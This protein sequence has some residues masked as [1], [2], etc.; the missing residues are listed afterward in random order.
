MG[1]PTPVL[2]LAYPPANGVKAGPCRPSLAAKLRLANIL[3]TAS[4][5]AIAFPM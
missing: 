3:F 4:F 5:S 1:Y 2:E